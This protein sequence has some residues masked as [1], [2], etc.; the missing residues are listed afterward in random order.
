MEK[1]KKKWKTILGIIIVIFCID[2]IACFSDSSKSTTKSDTSTPNPIIQET[3]NEWKTYA[4]QYIQIKNVNCG[5]MNSLL[6]GRIPG[7]TLEI[8]NTGDKTISK[9]TLTIYF[10]DENGN[11]IYED[12]MYIID[13]GSLFDDFG[14]LKPNYSWKNDNGTFKSFD[15]VPSEWKEG[16]IRFEITELKFE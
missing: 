9:L 6:N 5:Y 15:N 2:I 1:K 13:A 10:Q 12:N 14:V 4:E 3:K 7:I 8:K 16:A 11:D